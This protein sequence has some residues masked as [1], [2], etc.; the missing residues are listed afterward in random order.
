MEPLRWSASALCCRKPAPDPEA[1]DEVVETTGLWMS[2]GGIEL[3]CWIGED[4]AAPED[5]DSTAPTVKEASWCTGLPIIGD[6][7]S[8]GL[9]SSVLK[10]CSVSS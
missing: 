10:L 5:I 6:S 7:E 4:L 9:F 3:S 8:S 2:G 1:A